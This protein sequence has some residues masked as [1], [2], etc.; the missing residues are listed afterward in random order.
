MMIVTEALFGFFV[1]LFSYF[2]IKYLCGSKTAVNLILLCFSLNYALFIRPVLFYFCLLAAV[3]FFA[4]WILKKIPLLHFFVFLACF[5]AAAGGWSYRN[6]RH[7]GV[8]VYAT[9]T[10]DTMAVWHAAA[11]TSRFEKM[12]EHEAVDYH[13]L[14]FR[15]E[16][17]IAKTN[18]LNETQASRLRKQY[19]LAHMKSHFWQ[20]AVTAL[21]GL[22]KVLMGPLSVYP[23]GASYFGLRGVYML[24]LFFIY[25]VY[26]AGLFCAYKAHKKI[27]APYFYTERVLGGCPM[28]DRLCPLPRPVLPAYSAGRRCQQ[29]GR[30]S[31]AYA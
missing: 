19:S 11:V 15:E 12:T 22:I 20:Y 1:A 14:Q 26:I 4:A 6:Y 7:S 29:R 13:R 28:F 5:L 16:F 10:S 21:T 30:Y 27:S 2:F 17:P 3:A 9:S 25:L 18:E 8:F 24:Y 31:M 23:K